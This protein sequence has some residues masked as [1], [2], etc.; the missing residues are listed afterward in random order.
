M[1]DPKLDIVRIIESNWNAANTNSITPR[2]STGWYD[3]KNV[4][5]QISVTNPVETPNSEGPT[6]YFG[7]GTSGMP[8]QLFDG[9]MSVIVW[10]PGNLRETLSVNPKAFLFNCREELRRICNVKFD[11][12]TDIDAIAWLGGSEMVDDE[13][14]PVI[15][16]FNG[17]VGYNY[18][19]G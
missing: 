3:K 19:T 16:R 14:T 8:T 13:A 11:Q 10:V 9:T 15:Y 12:G 7:A 4:H 17:E 5:P 18:Y 1:T 6:G 2:V